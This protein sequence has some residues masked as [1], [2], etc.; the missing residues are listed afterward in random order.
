MCF[1]AWFHPNQPSSRLALCRRRRLGSEGGEHHSRELVDGGSGARGAASFS[2]FHALNT[3]TLI[4][5]AHPQHKHTQFQYFR[6]FSG[7]EKYSS[8]VI[9]AINQDFAVFHSNTAPIMCVHRGVEAVQLS[10]FDFFFFFFLQLSLPSPCMGW[11][12]KQVRPH[13]HPS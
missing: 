6:R 11:V 3:A 8:W 4:N 12:S 9:V 2:G 13:S 1:F 10:L 5:S 7:C